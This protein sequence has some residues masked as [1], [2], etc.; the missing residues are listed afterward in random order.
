MALPSR[1]AHRD[2]FR[3]VVAPRGRS[4]SAARG[5]TLIEIVMVIAL[6]VAIVA[7]TAGV[8]GAGL[9][10]QQLRGA[11]RELAAQLRYARTRAIVSGEQQVLS[12]DAQA[13]TW[14]IPGHRNGEIDDAIE[15]VAVGA[16]D[17]AAPSNVATYRFFPDGASTGG[18]VR[19]KRGDAEWRVDVDWLTGEVRLARGSGDA[20]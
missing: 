3:P 5:F 11:A 14:N 9:P 12:L 18:H 15:I 17:T 4:R 20:P 16:R 1:P 10:G 2:T 8:L 13:R 7:L 19:L 6:V